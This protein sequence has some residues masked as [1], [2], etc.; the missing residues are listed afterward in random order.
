MARATKPKQ[1][2]DF[3]VKKGIKLI[4]IKT[5]ADIP[6]P[7]NQAQFRQMILATDKIKRKDQNRGKTDM[8]WAMHEGTTEVGSEVLLKPSQGGHCF[9]T[10]IPHA[11][12]NKARTS[13]VYISQELAPCSGCMK[14]YS[15]WAAEIRQHIVVYG[16][17]AHGDV[18]KQSFVIFTSTG[19]VFLLARTDMQAVVGHG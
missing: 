1:W 18:P 17:D 4:S 12:T 15:G 7:L 14:S 16:E 9:E 2:V 13:P 6:A 10:K 5:P 19:G 8:P 11:Y 3:E